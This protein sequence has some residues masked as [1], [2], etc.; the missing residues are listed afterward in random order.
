MAGKTVD[1]K[2][3]ADLSQLVSE[4]KTL[5]GMT[6][7]EAKKMAASLERQMKKA[8]K[9]SVKAANA[10]KKAWKASTKAAKSSGDAMEGLAGKLG[11]VEHVGGE[12]SSV[13]GG[14]AGAMNTVSPAAG[15]MAQTLGD[16]AGGIEMVARSGSRLAIPLAILTGA[17]LAATKAWEIYGREQEAVQAALEKTKS[18]RLA[19]ASVMLSVDE[20][21]TDA[22][23]ELALAEGKITQKEFD[24]YS[25]RMSQLRKSVGEEET[26]ADAL[27]DLKDEAATAAKGLADAIG[28][29]S[30]ARVSLN[31]NSHASV[32]AYTDANKASHA[33]RGELLMA[34]K[35]Y[36]ELNKTIND[37]A[38][39]FAEVKER[40]RQALDQLKKNTSGGKRARTVIQQL[41]EETEKLL[42]KEE[43]DKVAEMTQHLERLEAA[44]EGS[45]K[46]ANK[47]ARAIVDTTDAIA[48]LNAKT[49]A[50]DLAAMVAEIDRLAPAATVDRIDQLAAAQLDLFDAI[51][52]T[53]DATGELGSKLADVHTA[54]RAESK[55]TRDAIIKDA[56][57]AADKLAKEAADIKAAYLD[58]FGDIASM[59]AD[60][61]TTIATRAAD[62]AS[63][64][65][66]LLAEGL[67]SREAMLEEERATRDQLLEESAERDVSRELAASESKIATLTI[68][69]DAERAALASAEAAK[70]KAVGDAF[71][72][73]KA[74]NLADIAMSTAAAVASALKLPPPANF[75]M[76]GVVAALGATQAGLVASQEPPTMHLGGIVGGPDERTI[77]ARAG[78]GILT[79]QGVNAIGGEAG[80][81]SAN[82]GQGGGPLV[83]QYIYKHKVLDEVLTDSVRRGGPIG[84]AINRRSP[85]GRRNPHGR[86]AS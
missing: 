68:A 43:I 32:V 77:T 72:L 4:M 53:G 3:R 82:R 38:D 7:K 29:E 69:A 16:V 80:V 34:R 58:T 62:A 42:P 55:K 40:R 81:A 51:D 65:V 54:I 6:E 10:T 41:R 85:R 23:K 61:A 59:S 46:A 14:M 28:V 1:L 76:A 67:D 57:D 25:A 12:T 15:A 64:E 78:E 19:L 70:A 66:D 17:V 13:M 50:D 86:R 45:Q 22:K 36:E 18:R 21:M 52:A 83:V 35:E 79:R 27:K 30:D 84:S 74:L 47:L 75:I 8:E 26:V 11:K 31:R 48:D 49:A 56:A 37:N 24:R 5:P 20:Q 71:A 44:A 39:A 73:S 2:F 63:A 60:I 9:A 33:A